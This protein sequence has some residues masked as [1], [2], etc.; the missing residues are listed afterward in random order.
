MRDASCTD[1]HG[2]VLT[3]LCHIP[4][5]TETFEV[6]PTSPAVCSSLILTTPPTHGG[7]YLSEEALRNVCE[8]LERWTQDTVAARGGLEE[9]LHAET[10]A[11]SRGAT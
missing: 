6:E 10:A 5:P 11:D 1:R 8:A 4:G 3:G 2:M 9:F 7:E